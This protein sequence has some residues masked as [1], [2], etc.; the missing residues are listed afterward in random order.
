MVSDEE[1]Q[2]LE[3]RVRQLEQMVA[4][5]L[6]A[7]PVPAVPDAAAAAAPAGEEPMETVYPNLESWVN[8]EFAPIYARPIGGEFRWCRRW[9]EHVEAVSRLESL[10]R[11]WEK[12]RLDP[13]FGMAV[14]YRDYLDISL[15]SVTS[16]RGPFARCSPERHEPIKPLPVDPAPPGYWEWPEDDFAGY[17]YDEATPDRLAAVPNAYA[18]LPQSSTEAAP[19]G[20]PQQIEEAPQQYPW[21]NGQGGGYEEP[22]AGYPQESAPYW[23]PSPEGDEGH[24]TGRQRP[25][26]PEQS[27]WGSR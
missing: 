21:P 11:A 25:E 4:N 12:L 2:Y 27:P 1:I 14:W 20:W 13:V 3:L 22:G 16:A 23:E 5:L 26:A 6:S 18:A 9:W 10:W 15:G 8:E 7:P 19:V 17:G 24:G